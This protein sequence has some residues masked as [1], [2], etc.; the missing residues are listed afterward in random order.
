MKK[1][2]LETQECLKFLEQ[3]DV[4]RLGTCMDNEPYVI[5]VN[6]VLFRDKIFIH[7]GFKGKKIDNMKVNP[8][9]C[10]E[11]SRQIK[12]IPSDQA[13][14]I[15]AEFISVIVNGKV[16]VVSDAETKYE[17]MRAFTDKYSHSG[18]EPELKLE[19]IHNVNILEISIDKISGREC[20]NH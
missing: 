3:E 7:T 8:L 19:D 1:R 20:S 12:V 10:F 4:G 15:S 18:S 9:V 17:V 2:W 13:C 11:A 6:F 16:N 5:P 14:K